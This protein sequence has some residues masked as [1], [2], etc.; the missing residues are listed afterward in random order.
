[1]KKAFFYFLRHG[2]TERNVLGLTTGQ[3]DVPL[4]DKGIHQ[5]HAV[6]TS[7]PVFQSVVCSSLKRART[8]AEIICSHARFPIPLKATDC[9][10]SEGENEERKDFDARVRKGLFE[11]LEGAHPLLIVAHKSV[12]KSIRRIL[13]LEKQFSDNCTP[14]VFQNKYGFWVATPFQK[15]TCAILT[16]TKPAE[17]EPLPFFATGTA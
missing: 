3:L 12:E 2:E 15:P 11:A 14:Y 5:T 7:L 16:F 9:F 4:N 10:Q 1:M 13:N 17:P 6:A 8:T